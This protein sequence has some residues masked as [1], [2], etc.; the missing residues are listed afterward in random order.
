[1]STYARIYMM[2]LYFVGFLEGIGC[3]MCWQLI[4]HWL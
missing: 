3:G 1:M 4:G 2:V